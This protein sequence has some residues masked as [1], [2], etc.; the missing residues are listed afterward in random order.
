VEEMGI[1]KMLLLV[2]PRKYESTIMG[3]WEKSQ[4]KISRWFAS[5]M[6]SSIF[7]GVLTFFAAYVLDVEYGVSFGLL[8]GVT[9]I[10]PIIGPFVAGGVIAGFL[11]VQGLWVKALLMLIIFILIQQIEGNILTPVLTKR[12][13]GLPASLVLV[14]LMVGGKLWGILGAILTIPLIGLLYEFLRD[15]LKKKKEKEAAESGLTAA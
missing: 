6:V 4:M 5:R 8:G 10:V 12:F 11:L 7:V 9:N 15:F 1:E 13:I 14:S 3:L 2:S